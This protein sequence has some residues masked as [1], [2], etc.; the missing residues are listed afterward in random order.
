MELWKQVNLLP[1]PSHGFL[2][3]Y[4]ELLQTKWG[5]LV[6]VV[7]PVSCPSPYGRALRCLCGG[8][9]RLILICHENW[10]YVHRSSFSYRK[11]VLELKRNASHSGIN[12]SSV[13]QGIRTQSVS[14]TWNKA[15]GLPGSTLHLDLGKTNYKYS[16]TL[17]TF[18]QV[19]LISIPAALGYKP[20]RRTT[21]IPR[22]WIVQHAPVSDCTRVSLQ[23]MGRGRKGEGSKRSK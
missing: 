23:G 6:V 21:P 12:P 4:D 5:D 7:V 22:E 1:I 17:P 8:E 19:L 14:I 11:A 2:H 9:L 10:R 3:A 15:L 20:V 16:R 13:T 18:A